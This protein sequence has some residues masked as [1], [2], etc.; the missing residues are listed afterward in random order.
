MHVVTSTELNVNWNGARGDFFRPQRGIHQGDPIS[1]YLFVLC[2]D[3]LSHL[4]EQEIVSGNWRA[5][6][7]GSQGPRIYHLM[8]M[9]DLL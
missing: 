7:M 5:D 9:D 1:P 3:K 8:F 6:K 4:I 2:M